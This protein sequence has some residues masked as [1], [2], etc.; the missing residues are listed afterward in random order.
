MFEL[1]KLVRRNI[2]DLLPYSSARDEFSG[3]DGVFLDA[4]ENPFG[5]LNRYPDPYQ[6]ALKT[7][8]SVLK[9]IPTENI[10]IGNGSDEIIDLAY[11]IFCTPGVDKALTFSPTYGMYEVSSKI[12]DVELI[13]VPLNESF[14]IDFDSLEPFLK[15]EHLKLIFICSPNN[16]TGNIIRDIDGLL[17]KFNGIVFVDEAYIDFTSNESRAYDIEDYPNLIVSQT[18]SKAWGLAAARVGTAYAHTDI[19]SLFSK[20]K[21]P[22]NI[23]ELNQQAAI[24]ALDQFS[25][26][27]KRKAIILEQRERLEKILPTL[28]VVERVYRSD[29]NFLLVEV[30]N[31]NDVYAKLVDRKVIT[32]NRSGLVRNS[33]RITVGSPEENEQ[34]IHAFKELSQ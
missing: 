31:A 14:Q 4:N 34:L 6:K 24:E 9:S 13:T 19:I 1:N 27:Q 21:P 23:S 7:K 29:A 5:A 16:P 25:E 28:S 12:N 20:V 30:R 18:F 8:L 32:R 33:I 2:L 17:Q 3:T 22:Y 11:R 15:D 10:F 26:F